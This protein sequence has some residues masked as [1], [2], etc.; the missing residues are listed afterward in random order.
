[1]L[2]K[3]TLVVM[4]V[5]CTS[6]A[7]NINPDPT[8]DFRVPVLSMIDHLYVVQQNSE[9]EILAATDA[10]GTDRLGLKGQVLEFPVDSVL[11]ILDISPD[12]Q[13]TTVALDLEG[14][15]DKG[16]DISQLPSEIVVR[17]KDLEWL[18]LEA[19][20]LSTSEDDEFGQEGFTYTTQL[21]GKGRGKRGMTY[22]LQ[23]VRLY[24]GRNC[25]V[26]PP[27]I[28]RAADARAVY[29]KTGKWVKISRRSWS[30]Y[31]KCTACFY[32]GGRQ[33]C[34]PRR[35]TACGH[36]AIKTGSVN[37]KGAGTRKVPGL[38][39]QNVNRP[40][41]RRPYK[42]QGCIIPKHLA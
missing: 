19:A 29:L 34:G 30:A 7:A 23:D 18:R 42:F 16:E 6:A 4:A 39:D 12:G 32:G 14:L 1:M 40:V 11:R 21:A 31:P 17:S 13:E 5:L 33:D 35:T 2:N 27:V 8:A 37:W 36:A 28:E 26:R 20:Q 9:I 22:C 24:A 15:A 38:R 25:G 3:L 10:D 41:K